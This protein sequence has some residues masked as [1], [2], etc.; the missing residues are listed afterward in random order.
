MSSPFCSRTVV[1]L[2][3]F[4]GGRGGAI[5]NPMTAAVDDHR[6]TALEEAFRCRADFGEPVDT[7]VHLKRDDTHKV[8]L[9]AC[10]T[11]V[12][13]AQPCSDIRRVRRR[14]GLSAQS[15]LGRTGR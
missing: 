5:S 13:D 15:T 6:G 10:D 8:A 14:N 3:R 12:T 2:A 1:T 7:Q 11:T 4:A 9:E